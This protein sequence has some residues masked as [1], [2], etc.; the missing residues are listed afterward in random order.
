MDNPRDNLNLIE[1][2][3]LK[4]INNNIEQLAKDSHT[5]F[6]EEVRDKLKNTVVPVKKCDTGKFDFKANIP[7]MYC[8]TSIVGFCSKGRWIIKNYVRHV[9]LKH[10]PKVSQTVQVDPAVVISVSSSK[11][12]KEC[13]SENST[14]ST[15]NLEP[16]SKKGN[17]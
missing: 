6:T 11:K 7:C 15:E 14:D 1:T 4:S 17:F 10:L 2:K 5:E 9:E 16:P 8:S 12:R 3:L 13:S